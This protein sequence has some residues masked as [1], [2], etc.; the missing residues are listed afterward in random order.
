MKAD[1]DPG[2]TALCRGSE[3]SRRSNQSLIILSPHP[4]PHSTTRK[5]VARIH[6]LPR[7]TPSET[8]TPALVIFSSFASHRFNHDDASTGLD[9]GANLTST[10]TTC[11][12][13]TARFPAAP[14]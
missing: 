12:A 8:T 5:Q 10:R 4:F 9:L 13:S 2:R 6:P 11:Q 3:W 14:C 1:V 7:E